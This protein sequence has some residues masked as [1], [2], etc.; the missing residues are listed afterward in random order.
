[1]WYSMGK[2]LV[3]YQTF[4]TSTRRRRSFYGKNESP[5]L[6][7]YLNRS[8]GYMIVRQSFQGFSITFASKF[9]TI[10]YVPNTCFD[11]LSQLAVIMS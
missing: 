11:R 6:G 8:G 2:C 5:A 3:L 7:L 10:E 9:K 1:M 4:L